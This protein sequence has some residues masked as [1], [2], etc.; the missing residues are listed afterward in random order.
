MLTLDGAAWA[1]QRMAASMM[2]GTLCALL[3]V[4]AQAGETARSWWPRLQFQPTLAIE[5]AVKALRALPPKDP[6][7]AEWLAVQAEAHCLLSQPPLAL[8]AAQ[9]GLALATPGSAAAH[10]LDLAQVC[11][12]T[13]SQESRSLPVLQRMEQTLPKGDENTHRLVDIL[14][15]RA[16][17]LIT[18]GRYRDA[19]EQLFRAYPLTRNVDDGSIRVQQADLDLSLAYTYQLLH[20]PDESQAY[21]DKALKAMARQAPSVRR[22]I[23]EFRKAS[24][25]RQAGRHPEAKSWFERSHATAKAI[26]DAQGMAYA[27]YGQGNLALALKDYP[28]A[29]RYFTEAR[30]FFEHGS[31]PL[32]WSYLNLGLARV[33]HAGKDLRQAMAL[34]DL[35]V[36]LAIQHKNDVL[37]REIYEFRSYLWLDLKQPAK[38]YD[39]LAESYDAYDRNVEAQSARVVAEMQTRFEVEQARQQNLLLAREG[40]LKDAKLAEQ[41]SRHRFYLAAGACLVLVLTMVSVGWWRRRRYANLMEK[42]ANHDALTGLYNRRALQQMLEDE[43]VRSQRYHLPMAVAILDIDHFKQVNDQWGHDVGDAVLQA[44][45]SLARQAVRVE[46]RLGRWGGEEFVLL[47]PHTSLEDAQHVLARL[48]AQQRAAVRPPGAPAGPAPTFSAGLTVLDETDANVESMLHRADQAL[49]AAKRS[50]RDHYEV[51]QAGD[52][53]NPA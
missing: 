38:A 29:E 46:D 21:L 32:T 33:A 20:Q 28:D 5:S 43:R 9:E 42:L 1:W 40:A 25:L 24:G 2:R 10:R 52:T 26:G 18:L 4:P 11:G 51:L 8:R 14:A 41:A 45:A 30:P 49:Y 36:D 13:E 35:V 7:R 48:Q 23:G 37:L 22:S 34:A 15:A 53:L 39:D 50:G 31:D 6:Q 3:W 19:L 17:V 27:R 44:F 47:M 12:I 16:D